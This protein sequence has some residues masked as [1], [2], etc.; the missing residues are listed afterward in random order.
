MTHDTNTTENKKGNIKKLIELLKKKSVPIAGIFVSSYILFLSLTNQLIFY[1]HPDYKLLAI[2]MSIVLLI[3][4]LIGIIFYQQQH[5]NLLSKA[6][7][8]PAIIVFLLGVVIKPTSLTSN[9]ALRRGI[10]EEASVLTKNSHIQTFSNFG[11]DTRNYDISIWLKS[12]FI[13]PDPTQYIGKK[14]SVIGFYHTSSDIPNGLFYISRYVIT[15][16]S[17]DARAV[18]LFAEIPKNSNFKEGDWVQVDGEF[19]N[20]EVN[21]KQTPVVKV[22]NIKSTLKPENSYIY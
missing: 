15:C 12:I 3:I 13:N 5:T 11:Q 14:L 21:G 20:I 7:L 4:S 6:V 22:S 8:I 17:V 2:F 9:T 16:C 10:D 18:G 19:N 1:I